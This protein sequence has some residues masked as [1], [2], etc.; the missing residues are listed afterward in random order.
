L[1]Q[2]H[3][4]LCGTITGSNDRT[5]AFCTLWNNNWNNNWIQLLFHKVQNAFVAKLVKHC[6]PVIVPQSAK[7][8]CNKIG[9]ALRSHNGWVV[10]DEPYKL[11]KN[12]QFPR[13]I[14]IVVS[15]MFPYFISGSLIY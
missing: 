9:K 13:W 3:F 1:L 2:K 14:V 4:A 10:E 15:A 7:Y 6:A 11:K 12:G 8:F 5:K